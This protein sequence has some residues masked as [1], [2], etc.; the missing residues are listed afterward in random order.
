MLSALAREY[1]DTLRLNAG[2]PEV[3]ALNTPETSNHPPVSPFSKGSPAA[4][5]VW[6]VGE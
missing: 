6:F 5:D 4:V 3:F 2:S 1:R